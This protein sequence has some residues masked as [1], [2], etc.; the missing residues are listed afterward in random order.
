VFLTKIQAFIAAF[1]K[2]YD[3]NPNL[4]FVDIR[5]YGNWGEGHIGMLGHNSKLVL[6]SSA[7]LQQN[8]LLPYVTAFPHTQLVPDGNPKFAIGLFLDKQDSKPAYKL[9]I[10]G[11]TASGWYVLR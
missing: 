9:G 4:A 8:Y 11:R 10:Q 2:R 1:G 6:T 7:S 3:G 5:D